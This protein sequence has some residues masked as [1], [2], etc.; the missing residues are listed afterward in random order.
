MQCSSCHYPLSIGQKFCTSCGHEAKPSQAC[1]KCR[2]SFS[3]GVKFCTHCGSPTRKSVTT[4]QPT[5][6][7][8]HMSLPLYP[9][10]LFASFTKRVQAAIIDFILMFTISLI[11]LVPGMIIF[12]LSEDGTTFFGLILGL[13]YRASMES[14]SYQGTVGKIL[15]GI[16]VVGMDNN[17]I[18]FGRALLRYFASYFSAFFLG[19]GF[20]FAL[21]TKRKQ[22][23][24]DLLVETVVVK[25]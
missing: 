17:R 13:L 8:Q 22:A 9:T 3:P 18:S 11:I 14:S 24:H 7:H 23:L 12:N 25:R 10:A 5:S 1:S 15:V 19:A 2:Q 16:K 20:L 21:F 4:S 6:H